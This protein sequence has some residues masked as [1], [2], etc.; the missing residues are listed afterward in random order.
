MFSNKKKSVIKVVTVMLGILACALMLTA[1]SGGSN[2]E[3]NL[4]GDT[5]FEASGAKQTLHIVS[6]SEN[7]E[8]EPLI[9][10][11]ANEKKINVIMDYQGSLDIMRLLD[12]EVIDYDAVW[13]ASSLWVSVGDTRHRVKNL[14]S[15]STTPVVFGI[16]KSLAESLGFIGKDVAVNDILAA[17]KAGKLKFTMTS[18]TQSNSGASAYIGFIYALL[19]NPQTLTLEALDDPTLQQN[20]RDLLS[21]VER[22]SGSS[23]WLKDLYLAGDYDS[24][25]N[26]EALI[27]SANQT[28]EA[29]GKEPLYVIYP[30]D[31]LTIADSPLGFISDNGQTDRNESEQETA[32]LAFQ[33]YIMSESVQNEI[34]RTGRRTGYSG[35]STANQDI[36]RSDWG[37]DTDRVIS[38][39]NM[40]KAEVL[41]KALNL[42]Q[43]NLKKPSATIYCLDFSGSMSGDGR[44]QLVQALSQVM[45][46]ENAQTN[47]L[48]ASTQEYNQYLLFDSKII[49]QL[50]VTGNGIPLSQAYD[51][52]AS[53]PTG[54]STNLYGTAI[55]A[56]KAIQ[57]IDQNVYS[58]AIV[59][60]TD[61]MNNGE[62]NFEDFK[63]FYESQNIDVPVFAILFGS[64]DEKELEEIAELT[65][66][67]VFDGRE[68]LIKAFQTVRGYN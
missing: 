3:S 43:T 48:Q 42:Y 25:V 38:A 33:E 60:M 27:I 24:M 34:Q 36:F 46:D 45:I 40:P 30:R 14:E 31:G 59:L 61:G 22:S 67:R 41:F 63:Q 11:F 37:I 16:K 6:G 35:V 54:D 8:L 53:T 17:I 57:T 9:E 64:A 39:M 13:P 47:F 68:N 62:Y 20:L 65:H 55:E 7:K 15:T 2:A 19:N 44:D 12:Q 21:G 51:Q 52:I 10:K 18:A 58:P 49:K 23:D 5:V 1:C 26:Y 4:E 28:L 29:E 56:V 66:G 32:F 50:E